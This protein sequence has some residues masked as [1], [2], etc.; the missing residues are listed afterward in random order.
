MNTI[1]TGVIALIRAALTGEAQSLPEDID[2]EQ[3]LLITRKHDIGTM[4]YYGALNCGLEQTHPFVAALFPSVCKRILINEQQMYDVERVFAAF[5]EH[6]IS[7]MPL[8]GTLLKGMYPR[9]EMRSMGDADILI[10]TEEYDRIRPIMQDLGF[11]EQLESD[12]ELVWQSACAYIELHKRLIPSYN[13]DYYAYYGDGWKLAKLCDGTR[14]GMTDEDQM[15]YLFTHFAKHYRDAGIGIRHM[16]DLWVY[17]NRFAGMDEAYL[18][19]ELTKLSL[20]EFYVNVMAT[21]SVWF[22]SQPATDITDFITAIIFNSGVYGTSE[23]HYLSEALKRSKGGE[24]AK[25]VRWRMYFSIVFLPYSG[26]CEKYPVLKKCPVLLPFLWV[27]RIFTALL[28][29]RR[30]V[31]AQHRRLNT[32]QEENINDYHQAL[33]YV[34]LDFNFEE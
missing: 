1:Q 25:T 17:R 27:Y 19:L 18:R 14:Y 12:H 15:I 3:V 20:Y 21:L 7:Y 29:G 5:D 11:S 30:N 26:M 22:D 2:W 9:P 13:K 34:G 23:V 32:A 4:L 10:K 16:V 8:K 24:S 33:N 31:K 28:F 6:S